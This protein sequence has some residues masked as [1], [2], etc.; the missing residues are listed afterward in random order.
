MSNI[1]A[2]KL[3]NH[4]LACGNAKSNCLVCMEMCEHRTDDVDEIKRRQKSMARSKKIG[5]DC[6][7]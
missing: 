6:V 1:L 7:G 3:L 4:A 5:G 2:S